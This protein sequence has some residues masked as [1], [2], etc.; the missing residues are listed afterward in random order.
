MGGINQIGQF[1]GEVGAFFTASWTY[2]VWGFWALVALIVLGLLVK[3]KELGG[4]PAVWGV[5]TLGVAAFFYN[6]G[7]SGKGFI[8]YPSENEPE[9]SPVARGLAEWERRRSKPQTP[10]GGKRHYDP[11]RGWVNDDE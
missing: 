7:K 3:V 4:W 6:R 11:D 5:V 10:T 8:P 9:D 2:I 1:F